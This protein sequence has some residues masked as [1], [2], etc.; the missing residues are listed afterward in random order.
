MIGTKTAGSNPRIVAP[1]KPLPWQIDPWRDKSLVLL[2]TGSA[3]GGKSR[4]AGE[5]IHAFMKKY[6]GATGLMLRKAR[7]YTGKSIVPFLKQTVIGKDPT[8]KKHKSESYFQYPNGSVLFWGGMKDDSQREALRS[9]GQDGAL[10][11]VWIEEANAFTRKD[12]D[13]LLARMRGKAASWRQI[14]LTTNPDTPAHWIYTDLILKRPA[15]TAAYFSSAKDNPHN[16]PEYL[17]IL[18][19]LTGT[20]KQRLAD[21]L[22][23]QAEGAVYD[24]FD[25]ATHVID[26]IKIPRTWRRIRVVDFGFANPFVCQWWAIDPE[27]RMYLYREIYQT[28]RLV[29]DL[30]KEIIRLSEGEDIEVTVADH[31][32]ED[33]ATLARHGVPTLPAKKELSVGIQKVKARLAKDPHD[34][35]Q[36]PRLFVIRG[37]LVEEDPSLTKAKKPASTEAEFTGYA[38]PKSQDGKPVKEVPVKIN[39][40]GMD[41]MRYAVMY[42]DEGGSTVEDVQELGTIDDY[43]SPFA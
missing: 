42:V 13:E 24:E 16:P 29:E 7:E 12:F 18:E 33:R 43:E 20:L 36:R 1:Y 23:V 22:W 10:D 40:H 15:K 27:G 4:L 14:V 38:W 35:K 11:F 8:V 30:A 3:G 41:A 9:I 31:D 34:L 5:K 17:E 32:A 39:D 26:P 19:M 25:T 21:G 6:P 28:N 37:A 2:L